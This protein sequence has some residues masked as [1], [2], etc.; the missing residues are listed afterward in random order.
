MGTTRRMAALPDRGADADSWR[1]W[2]TD[3]LCPAE[4]DLIH[5]W[6][7]AGRNLTD[8]ATLI[9]L[10]ANGATTG[11][12]FAEQRDLATPTRLRSAVFAETGG[13]LRVPA[14]LTKG[15]L[16]DI[17]AALCALGKVLVDRDDR[18]EAREW[19]EALLERS[20]AINGIT[21]EDPRGTYDAI[22][23]LNA[24]PRF[25]RLA[26]Q[27]M[28]DPNLSPNRVIKPALIYDSMGPRWIRVGE[29][30]AYVR[31]VIGIHGGSLTARMAEI[32]VER[33][34]F[35]QRRGA[36]HPKVRVYRVPEG[37]GDP[38]QSPHPRLS[39]PPSA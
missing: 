38:A 11:Y 26:A 18:D 32:G 1:G 12:R 5:G 29:L 30:Q 34:T 19:V 17:W 24:R 10:H 6:E 7:R 14:G 39:L 4:G 20:D 37:L 2:L 3:A 21:L 16:E 22:V 23:F 33:K 25:D 15:E 27:M 35:E 13:E 28:L 31:H 8:P 9:V 36:H